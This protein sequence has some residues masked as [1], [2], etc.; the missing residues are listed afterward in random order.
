MVCRDCIPV[1]WNC[2]QEVDMKI[3]FAIIGAGWRA[4]YYVRIARALPEIFE[5]VGI[6][7]RSEEKAERTAALTAMNCFTSA[8]ALL[9]QNPEFIVMAVSKQNIPSVVLEWLERGVPVLS[10][11]PAALDRVM[12]ERLWTASD[13]G[14]NLSVAEQYMHYPENTARMKL[15]EKGLIGTPYFLYLSK[16]HEY[17]AMSMIRSYL[18]VSTG[19]GYVI[20]A[21]SASF[22]TVQTLT[23]KERIRDGR[24][25]N[26]TRTAAW[27]RFGSGK[28]ALYDFDS[29]Q[30]C[31]LIRGSGIRVQGVSGEITNEHVRWLDESFSEQE[32]VL[33]IRTRTVETE[34]ENPNFQRFEEVEEIRFQDEVLYSPPFG[35]CSL[36]QDETAIASLLKEMGGYVRGE[37]KVPYPLSHALMDAMMAMDLRKAVES[38]TRISSEKDDPWLK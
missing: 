25:I 34:S 38:G 17:H 26:S 23:R 10:E 8:E 1:E 30:Y 9:K 37:N 16:A 20:A 35:L 22:P 13:Q 19:E 29:E 32:A 6:F 24:I 21:D 4:Q 36:S 15:I 12:L 7:C 3:R 5:C 27:I 31:S 11:T 14:K 33:D 28:A 2:S 18:Q